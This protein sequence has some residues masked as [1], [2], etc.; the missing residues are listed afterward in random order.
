[1]L[2]QQRIA[3]KPLEAPARPTAW[4]LHALFSDAL[5]RLAS[6]TGDGCQEPC[7]IKGSVRGADRRVAIVVNLI[8][9]RSERERERKRE[10]ESLPLVNIHSCSKFVCIRADLLFLCMVY[11]ADNTRSRGGEKEREIATASEFDT[12][13][14]AAP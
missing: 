14:W 10:R 12:S 5:A 6:T 7:S 8:I 3:H 9:W 2:V 11:K 4:A 1:M 13:Q